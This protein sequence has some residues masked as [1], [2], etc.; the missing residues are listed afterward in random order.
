M[1]FDS[2]MLLLALA[3]LPSHLASTSQIAYVMYKDSLVYFV[4]VTVVNI[5]ILAIEARGDNLV[6]VKPAVVPFTTVITFAMGTRV[7][8][9][10]RLL[11]NREETESMRMLPLSRGSN[12]APTHTLRSLGTRSQDS[13]GVNVTKQVTVL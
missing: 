11:K 10:L 4:L 3:R 12:P 9:N 6:Y 13:S 7:F 1:A 8:L 2:I 5:V